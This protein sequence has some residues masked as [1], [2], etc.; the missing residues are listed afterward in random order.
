MLLTKVRTP[1]RTSTLLSTLLSACFFLL[2]LSQWRWAAVI[3]SAMPHGALQQENDFESSSV[4]KGMKDFKGGRASAR[5][6]VAG[7]VADKAGG[8]KSSDSEAVGGG[9][10]NR[11]IGGGVVDDLGWY[12]YQPPT[13]AA[14]ECS[15]RECFHTDHKCRTCRDLPSDLGPPPPVPDGWIPDVTVLRRMY[16]AGVDAEGNAWPPALDQELCEDIGTSG[17]EEDPNKPLLEA[18]PIKAEPMNKKSGDTVGSSNGKVPSPA[19]ASGLPRILCLV[20]TMES[21]HATTIRAMRETWA[22]GCDGFLAFSTASDPR[23]PAISIK[24]DGPEKYSNMWQKSRS[25]WHFVG[26]HYLEQFDFFFIGGDDMFVIPQNLREYLGTVGDP[27]KGQ[28]VGRRFLH[29]KRNI[30]YNS[31]GPGYALSRGTLRKFIDHFDDRSCKPTARTFMEDVMIAECLS[32]LGIGLT[33]TRDAKGRER[34]HHFSPGTHYTWEPPK[35]G[36][37]RDWYEDYN[38]EWGIKLGKEC[39][40][41]DSV[42][43][44][45][46]KKPA[47]VRHIHAM[48][49]HCVIG[50]SD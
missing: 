1:L 21:A 16:L 11:T 33:D 37:K 49:Y 39:C 36:Q 4:E 45:Y 19:F 14:M 29:N 7:G 42:S 38:K 2:F 25:I 23:I 27:N 12:G 28:F 30:Y 15:W 40:A 13:P 22:G 20:Y 46:I 50:R 8:G 3:R 6:A 9:S 35:K 32:S 31:G 26:T 48:L 17:E 34:F 24:H 41:P 43:F 5:A 10:E 44:H 18:V 47:M